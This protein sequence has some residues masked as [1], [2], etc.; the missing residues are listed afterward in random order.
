VEV[1]HP[2]AVVAVHSLVAQFG[3]VAMPG[4]SVGFNAAAA[5]LWLSPDYFAVAHAHLPVLLMVGWLAAGTGDQVH[6]KVAARLA[7][8]AGPPGSRPMRSSAP[9]ATAGP[10]WACLRPDLPGGGP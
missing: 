2:G 7:A 4:R 3:P 6:L 1:T 9:L 8:V 5:Y 10:S